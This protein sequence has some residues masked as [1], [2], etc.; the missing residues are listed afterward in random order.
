MSSKI[1]IREITED[2]PRDAPKKYRQ[3]HSA[4]FV[5]INPH[6]TYDPADPA[7]DEAVENLRMAVRELFTADRIQRQYVRIKPAD[8]SWD[9]I[10]N[11][12]L[13][14]R[15]GTNGKAG[16]NMIHAHIALHIVH[17]SDISILGSE[18]RNAIRERLGE[19]TYVNLKF[20][21]HADDSW[22]SHFTR[23][24]MSRNQS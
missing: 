23:E 15:I 22:F 17:R 18:I 1:T 8:H 2:R 20:G 11:A 21:S 24:Y 4:V 7:A 9:N 14:Y 16:R 6:K 10:I 13:Q 12:K 5:T 3:R 19:S